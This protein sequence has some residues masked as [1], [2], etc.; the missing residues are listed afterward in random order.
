MP[1]TKDLTGIFLTPQNFQKINGHN[2]SYILMYIFEK[3]P[4][5]LSLLFI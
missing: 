4:N 3:C 2:I 1:V 5:L